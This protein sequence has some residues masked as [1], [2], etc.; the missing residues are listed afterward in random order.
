M[1]T[2]C[3]DEPKAALLKKAKDAVMGKATVDVDE[4]VEMKKIASEAASAVTS[5]AAEHAE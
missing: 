5:V 4:I 1:E 2:G 3:L